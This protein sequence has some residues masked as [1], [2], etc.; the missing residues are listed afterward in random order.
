M[1]NHFWNKSPEFLM[2]RYTHSPHTACPVLLSS[3]NVSGAHSRAQSRGKCPSLFAS[4]SGPGWKVTSAVCPSCLPQ[5]SPL[6]PAHPSGSPCNCACPERYQCSFSLSF[7]YTPLRLCNG[8]FQVYREVGRT[9]SYTHCQV[10]RCP[11]LCESHRCLSF[12]FKLW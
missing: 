6:L 9:A 8:N 2:P 5:L 4:S 12:C 10:Q 7:K 11:V 3:V 1:Y